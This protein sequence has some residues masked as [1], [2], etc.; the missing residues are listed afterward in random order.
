LT[1]WRAK[2]A[3]MGVRRGDLFLATPA[4]PRV[5]SGYA[6]PVAPKSG[7]EVPDGVASAFDGLGSS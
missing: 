7:P 5:R 4:D 6:E 3:M 1:Q 2:I